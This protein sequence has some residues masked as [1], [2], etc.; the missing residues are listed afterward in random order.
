MDILE[1]YGHLII[2]IC[3]GTMAAV[4]FS[5]KDITIRDTVSVIGFVIV[6]LTVVPLA[7][8]RKNKKIVWLSGYPN[9]RILSPLFRWCDKSPFSLPR[10]G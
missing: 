3:L 7:I 9:W 5:T 4:N 6:F 8:Y 1:K 2:L 10:N